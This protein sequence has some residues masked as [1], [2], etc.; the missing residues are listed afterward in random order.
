MKYSKATKEEILKKFIVS[1][2]FLFFF[3]ILDAEEYKVYYG[4]IHA[5]CSHSDGKG[6][7]I[8]AY[9]YARDMA[10]LDFFAL[11]DH[12]EQLTQDELKET[13]NA[14]DST[15]IEGVFETLWG[16]EW[17]SPIY[18][19]SNMFMT[20]HFYSID[21]YINDHINK[22]YTELI[23]YPPAFMQ[24]NHPDYNPNLPMYN[25]RQYEYRK[26]VDEIVSLI[27]VKSAF[28]TDDKQELSY[29][30]ALDKGWHLSPVY[31]QDN[32]SPDWGTKN[33]CRA[34]VWLPSLSRENLIDGLKK[35]RTY[36]TCNKNA[37]VKWL[38]DGK[39]AGETRFNKESIDCE[40]TLSDPDESDVFT[41]VDI[42]T[43]GGAVYKTIDK[44]EKDKPIKFG[45]VFS[46]LNKWFYLRIR[47]NGEV[48]IWTA[49]FYYERLSVKDAGFDVRGSV[50]DIND[51]VYFENEINNN[52]GSEGCGCT[53]LR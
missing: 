14:A 8:E 49:P 33:D 4:N 22:F 1:L 25:Y 31:N 29:I 2:S 28:D 48:A 47:V 26:D 20:E 37:I 18:N 30:Q 21:C 32:H 5:H 16:F 53:F 15:R 46:D 11:T 27:E 17:G 45:L 39:W 9:T 38:C 7:A 52:E 10:K 41:S 40:L 12:M 35:G 23:R 6:S 34:A 51:V 24:F 42:I 13:I 36:S 43:T 44:I 19:H 3:S 50:L